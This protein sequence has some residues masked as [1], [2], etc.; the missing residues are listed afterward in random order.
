MKVSPENLINRN[1]DVKAS[2]IM[3]K[4]KVK[5]F[6][7]TKL[8]YI[9]HVGSYGEIPFEEYMGELFG[10]AKENK[11][12]P[13]FNI[14]GRYPDN[15]KEIPE[16]ELRSQIGIAIRGDAPTTDR[17]SIMELPETEVASFKHA[18]PASEYDASYAA[19]TGWIEKNGY[20]ITAPPFEIYYKKPK[21]KNGQTILFSEIQFPVREK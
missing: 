9:E 15:P 1:A 8:A 18:A 4:I 6:R 11:A 21:I 14:I 3:A 12:K 20:E 5:R 16:A 10:W 7:A 2:D 13:S 17:I 19:L